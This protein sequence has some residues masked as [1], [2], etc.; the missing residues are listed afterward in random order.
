MIPE[1]PSDLFASDIFWK[2]I[3]KNK[4][5]DLCGGFAGAGEPRGAEGLE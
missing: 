2:T 1:V 3:L 5:C 4:I